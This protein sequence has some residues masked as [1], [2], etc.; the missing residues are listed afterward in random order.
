MAKKYRIIYTGII[1]SDQKY[2]RIIISNTFRTTSTQ[3][4]LQIK[5]YQVTAITQDKA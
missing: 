4:S 5:Q 2:T 3:A 1:N